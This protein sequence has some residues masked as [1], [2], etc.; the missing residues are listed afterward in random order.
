MALHGA[1]DAV[2]IVARAVG[3]VGDVVAASDHVD[4][5][6]AVAASDHAGAVDAVAASD[7]AGAV[8]AVV[9]SDHAGAVDAVVASDHVGAVDAVA[10]SDHVGAVDAVAAS[11][12]DLFPL[13]AARALW[14][15]V[16]VVAVVVVAVGTVVAKDVG[17]VVYVV[18]H[19]PIRQSTHNTLLGN[20]D[21]PKIYRYYSP[22]FPPSKI[23]SIFF[24]SK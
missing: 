3:A 14:T 4:A 13:V 19:H 5:V 10:A 1:M 15:V 21:L 16:V 18:A 20:R 24:N 11:P 17:T 6:D 7:H 23:K 22:I 2:A 12:G 9:A 8:D